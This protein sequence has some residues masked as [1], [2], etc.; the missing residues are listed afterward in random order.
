MQPQ[1]PNIGIHVIINL[2]HSGFGLQMRF[3]RRYGDIAIFFLF[4]FMHDLNTIFYYKV[5]PIARAGQK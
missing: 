3:Q 2:K 5:V 4:E 1:I